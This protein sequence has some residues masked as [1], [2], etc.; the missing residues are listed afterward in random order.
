VNSAAAATRN[1]AVAF[2]NIDAWSKGCIDGPCCSPGGPESAPPSRQQHWKEPDMKRAFVIGL[3]FAAAMALPAF[4]AE[5]AAVTPVH[6]HH[7]YRHIHRTTGPVEI[8]PN[9]TALAPA[10]KATVERPSVEWDY[11]GGN[12]GYSWEPYGWRRN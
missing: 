2:V 11:N 6:H 4:A 7:V 8:V 3:G 9:A 12:A 1:V 5:N 10:M